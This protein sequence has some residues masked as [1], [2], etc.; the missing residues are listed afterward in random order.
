MNSTY[1][2]K[3]STVQKAAD[4]KAASVL[5]SSAQSESLQRK[6]DMANNAT[7]RAEAPRPNNTGMPD[8]LKSGIESLSG[9]SMDDVRVHYNSS[10]PATVQALAYTQ[11]TDIHVAPGQE[12]CLPHEAWHVAQQMAGRVSP[13]TNINGMP[14]N[15][16]AALEYEA[17]VMGEKAV[18]CK[19]V[20]V[21]FTNGM[22]Q[23]TAIQRMAFYIDSVVH[24]VQVEGKPLFG[25]G[26]GGFRSPTL[27]SFVDLYKKEMLTYI[28][29]LIEM[30][31]PVALS[32]N[33]ADF[34]PHISVIITGGNWYISINSYV[35]EGL[36]S[37]KRQN[38]LNC[39]IKAK[40]IIKSEFE[41]LK[42]EYVEKYNI[43][44]SCSD[45]EKYENFTEEEQAAYIAYRWAAKGDCVFVTNPDADKKNEGQSKKTEKKSNDVP[46]AKSGK[47]TES[48]PSSTPKVNPKSVP[49]SKPA[50]STK[51]VPSSTPKVNSKSVSLSKPAESTKSVPSSTPKV[52]SKSVSSRNPVGKTEPVPLSTSKEKT[53]SVSSS[54]SNGKFQEHGEMYSIEYLNERDKERDKKTQW[55]N[56]RIEKMVAQFIGSD[57]EKGKIIQLISDFLKKYETESPLKILESKITSLFYDVNVDFYYSFSDEILEEIFNGEVQIDFDSV[58]MKIYDIVYEMIVRMCF[59]R[60]VRVGGSKTPCN[61]CANEM[62]SSSN[63]SHNLVG[64]RHVVL[65]SDK[66][67]SGYKNWWIPA[68]DKE[69]SSADESVNV[70]T[71]DKEHGSAGKTKD[72]NGG[73][74][75]NPGNDGYEQGTGGVV[76][77]GFDVNQD[78]HYLHLFEVVVP[79]KDPLKLKID[80]YFPLCKR[81]EQIICE[82]EG[83][84]DKQVKAWKIKLDE[85]QITLAGVKKKDFCNDLE[86]CYNN[87]LAFHELVFDEYN[88]FISQYSKDYGKQIKDYEIGMNKMKQIQEEIK[89]YKMQSGE[90]GMNLGKIKKQL[91]P[92]TGNQQELQQELDPLNQQKL[93]EK[94]NSLI[95]EMSELKDKQ[96]KLESKKKQLTKEMENNVIY[97]NLKMTLTKVIDVFRDNNSFEKCWNDFENNL[98]SDNDGFDAIEWQW[99]KN[100]LYEAEREFCKCISMKKRLLYIKESQELCPPPQNP[101]S[102]ILL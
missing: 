1:A 2:Q 8:N 102:C 30:L 48:I 72:T 68:K 61:K 84:N 53:K 4:T 64:K 93:Q 35:R 15:D 55:N 97:Y 90:I 33:N 92:K 9:F 21:S 45:I 54:G 57:E 16:N 3:S 40:K 41:N 51:S 85:N 76:L 75:I 12:K 24:T 38:L 18:Q 25:R 22:V 29:C 96:D 31:P 74:F 36:D 27:A 19:M 70:I 94:I 101:F 71:E 63:V 79:K 10:K 91:S 67:G 32:G 98:K 100:V 11:G 66:S 87:A 73:D 60:V 47:K 26:K 42:K 14:V 46:L 43:S 82:T 65:M 28:A 6:A 83:K 62:M 80:A 34:G 95:A 77:N 7:Q 23:N 17:D 56:D 86:T 88:D 49:L 69:L 20:G 78:L 52:N 44:E 39:S 81:I 59:E 89:K 13:T 50:E 99:T 37:K 58:R 5:D